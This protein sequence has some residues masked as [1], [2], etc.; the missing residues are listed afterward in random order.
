MLNLFIPEDG[1]SVFVAVHGTQNYAVGP[2]NAPSTDSPQGQLGYAEITSSQTGITTL[3][4]IAGL[5]V[6]VTVPAGR[7]IR[8][9]GYCPAF[10]SGAGIASDL[11]GLFIAEG[12]TQLNG[13]S[14]VADMG[15][16]VEAI[17][18]P[19]AGA[20]TYKIQGTHLFGSSAGIFGVGTGQQGFI[21]VEDI[22]P[23]D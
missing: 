19:S 17:L 21:L 12:S 18:T 9:K 5:A 3:T 20:H 22:G 14:L 15:G 13:L 10:Q 11:Y 2:Y 16:T 6:T 4:D 7:R 1:M 8:I 23:D